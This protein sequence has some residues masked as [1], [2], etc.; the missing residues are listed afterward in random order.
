M[1]HAEEKIISTRN[2][3]HSI[4]IRETHFVRTSCALA[5][6]PFL[7]LID[8]L[9]NEWKLTPISGRISSLIPGYSFV[10][11]DICPPPSLS[12]SLCLPIAFPFE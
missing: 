7:S 6:H 1:E 11:V 12:L 10:C 2:I 4:P 9:A 8:E 3:S 5:S